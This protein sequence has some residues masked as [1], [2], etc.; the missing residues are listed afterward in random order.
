MTASDLSDQTKSWDN[1]KHIAVS[2]CALPPVLEVLVLEF[3]FCDESALLFCFC[4]GLLFWKFSPKQ[5]SSKFGP[6]IEELCA[7]LFLT[8]KEW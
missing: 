5:N 3:G 6:I 4:T 1:T 8:S 2:G 7:L